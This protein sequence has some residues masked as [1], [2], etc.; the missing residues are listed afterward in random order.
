MA[1]LYSKEELGK[2]VVD[3]VMREIE[4]WANQELKYIGYKFKSP[5]CLPIG[6]N[7]WLAG[8]YKIVRNKKKQFLLYSDTNLINKFSIKQAAFLYATMDKLQRYE[9]A[10]RILNSDMLYGFLSEEL[11]ILLLKHK[12]YKKQGNT[13][14]LSLISAKLS[15]TKRKLIAAKRDLEKNLIQ[16]KYVK[17][18]D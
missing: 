3:D 15:D 2:K 17:V 7:T 10:T 18:W 11:E 5:I 9:L 13:F 16:A 14:K 12:K 8:R 1:E 6:K 4:N